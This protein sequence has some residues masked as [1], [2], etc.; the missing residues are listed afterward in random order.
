MQKYSYNVVHVG[1][2]NRNTIRH[3]KV[4]AYSP[5]GA[6]APFISRHM[7]QDEIRAMKENKR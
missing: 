4:Q 1:P 2:P 3:T 5:H 6:L 7:T